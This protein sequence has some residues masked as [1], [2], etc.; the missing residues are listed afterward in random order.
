LRPTAGYPLDAGRFK[1]DIAAAQAGL[2]IDD[3]T[4]WRNR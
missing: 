1:A 4:V 2:N 3:R